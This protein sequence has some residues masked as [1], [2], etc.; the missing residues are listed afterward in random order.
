MKEQGIVIFVSG[1]YGMQ[2]NRKAA[3]CG[4]EREKAQRTQ[5]P[6]TECLDAAPMGELYQ[7]RLNSVHSQ[8]GPGEPGHYILASTQTDFILV[9]H[10][11]WIKL[12]RCPDR[13]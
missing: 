11:P 6:R 9:L 1:E 7:I 13:E 10:N 4:G 2:E 5:G 8:N 3:R 12:R